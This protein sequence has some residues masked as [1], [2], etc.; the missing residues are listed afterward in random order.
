MPAVGSRSLV[1]VIDDEIYT[2]AVSDVRVKSAE[3]DSDFVSFADAAAGGGRDYVLAL[4]IKQ[5]TDADTLWYLIW[6]AAGTDV[7]VEI[8][9]HGEP[10]DSVPT[11][12]QPMLLGTAT[13]AEPDGDFLGGEANKSNTMRFVTEVEWKYTAKPVL[14]SEP[15]P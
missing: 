10:L 1:L 9:P 2:D 7:D 12:T 8:W 6:S 5:D 4:K 11:V 15:V 3:T 14:Y 13:V